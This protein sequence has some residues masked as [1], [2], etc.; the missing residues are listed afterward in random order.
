MARI[1]QHHA[2]ALMVLCLLVATALRVPD[3]LSAPP[4]LHYDEAANAL[5]SA[6]IGLEGKRPVFI[7]SYTGKEVLFFYLAGVIMRLV[8]DS[9][10]SL[11]L[12]AAFIG[13]L[14]IAA[15]Y[16]LGVEVTRD[17]RIGLL[18]ATLLAVSFWHLLFSRLGFRAISQPLLQAI[19]IAAL[20]RGLKHHRWRWFLFAGVTLGAT[21]YT[22]LAA[23]LFPILILLAALPL[24]LKWD[25]KW[26]RWK[27][28]LATVVTATIILI[29][30]LTYF[31]Q[32]PDA[33]WVRIGQVSPGAEGLPLSE[34]IWRSLQI[35]F[36]EGDPYIRF[37][38]PGEP[39]FGWFWG[40]LLLFG[41][42]ILLWRG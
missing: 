10:F 2:L 42:L 22:Y 11:R 38:L 16:W 36:W 39:L 34:S 40:G 19:T 3:L 25:N 27:Q 17:K 1:R 20:L 5:L 23:R 9:V 41:W 24:L 31:V 12:T 30:L 13:I 14:T 29:P 26:M 4:G 6:E 35:F 8:G 33:F 32:N 28:L 18:A 37:N 7:A 15:T 21:A